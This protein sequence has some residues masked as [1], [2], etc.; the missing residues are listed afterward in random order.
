MTRL[1]FLKQNVSYSKLYEH[2]RMRDFDEF[3]VNRWGDTCTFRVYGNS[4]ETY[5]IYER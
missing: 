5:K 3:V 4:K 1:E 2:I